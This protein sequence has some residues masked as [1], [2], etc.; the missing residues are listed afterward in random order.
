MSAST[1]AR[2]A[3]SQAV[4]AMAGCVLTRRRGELA[5][6]RVG[7]RVV[8]DVVVVV[9]VVFAAEEPRLEEA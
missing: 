4:Q 6:R 3:I 9:V 8:V 2:L 1:P 5:A 7:L